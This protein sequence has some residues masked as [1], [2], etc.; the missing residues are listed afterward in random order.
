MIIK[1]WAEL[2]EALDEGKRI[3]RQTAVHPLDP[4]LNAWNKINPTLYTM[5]TVQVLLKRGLLRTR[6]TTLDVV[7]QFDKDLNPVGVY[8]ADESPFVKAVMNGRNVSREKVCTIEIGDL[9]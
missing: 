1:T 9:M 6:P 8:M 7:V 5:S 4:R 3:E 2:G